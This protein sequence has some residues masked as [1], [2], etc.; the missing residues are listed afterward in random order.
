MATFCARCQSVCGSPKTK[1][2]P[3]LKISMMKKQIRNGTDP[4]IATLEAKV[5]GTIAGQQGRALTDEV[6][7]S[8]IDETG[9]SGMGWWGRR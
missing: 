5:P 9:Q 4:A 6:S 3:W 2:D 1:S 8:P 7:E